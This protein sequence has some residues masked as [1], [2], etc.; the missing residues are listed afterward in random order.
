MD[1][2]APN[3][4]FKIHLL[5]AVYALIKAFRIFNIHIKEIKVDILSRLTIHIVINQLLILVA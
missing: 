2:I 5:V 1:N 4:L 3:E